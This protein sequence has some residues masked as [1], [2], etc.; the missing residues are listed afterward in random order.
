MIKNII[1]L[2]S[3][4]SRGLIDKDK[5]NATKTFDETVFRTLTAL[6]NVIIPADGKSGSAEDAGVSVF[7]E[8]LCGESKT[9]YRRIL[10]VVVWINYYCSLRF[11]KS[12]LLCNRDQRLEVVQRLAFRENGLV[13]PSLLPGIELFA[14]LRREAL[15]AYFTSR[16]GIADLDY[17]G[18]QVVSEFV[19]CPVEVESLCAS[20]PRV[21]GGLGSRVGVAGPQD[22][23]GRSEAKPAETD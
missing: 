12:F 2:T 7:L 17:R 20:P 5:I 1:Q 4:L 14:F 22:R 13:D 3:G 15:S 23:S 6:C 11:A 21:R 8:Y 18:N 19:G 9:Y 10:G 16:L